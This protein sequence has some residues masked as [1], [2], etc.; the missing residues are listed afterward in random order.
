MKIGMA[1][2]KKAKGGTKK[3]GP[4]EK[5][6]DAPLTNGVP[7]PGTPPVAQANGKPGGLGVAEGAGKPPSTPQTQTGA[8]NAAAGKPGANPPGP[9]GPAAPGEAGAAGAE[10][11]QG[12]S[13]AD[14]LEQ[15]RRYDRM[16]KVLAGHLKDL[17]PLSKKVMRIF[18]SSTFTGE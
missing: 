11:D 4:K 17:P 18:T 14:L 10:E 12:E 1:P 7:A 2:K 15:K 6:K 13:E 8:A 5:N 3:K 16:M 9:G